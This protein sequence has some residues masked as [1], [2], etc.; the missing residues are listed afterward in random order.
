MKRYLIL[1][2]FTWL[3]SYFSFGQ[4]ILSNSSNT[5]S[6]QILNASNSNEDDL[7]KRYFYSRKSAEV[8][9][10]KV[11]LDFV[12]SGD[13]Q[14]SLSNG[15]DINA[16][17]GLGV[18]FELYNGNGD[19]ETK[20]TIQSLELEGIITVASTSD[21]II[22]EFEDEELINRR[23]FGT[24]VLNPISSKQSLYVNS[25]VFFNHPDDDD[26]FWKFIRR[27]I[28]HG[29]NMR[30]ITSNSVWKYNNQTSHL[31]ALYFRGGIFREFVP[32]N[33]RI[34][35]EGLNQGKVKYSIFL[36]LNYSYRNIIGDI[37]AD[38]YDDLREDIFG[39]KQTSFNGFEFNFGFR[40]NNLRAEFQMPILKGTDGSIEGLTDT[41]FL[42]SIK[43]I[44][45]FS[46]KLNNTEQSDGDE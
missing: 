28:L 2:M 6:G 18:V 22:A 34:E 30:V 29:V 33:H 46:L 1:C 11:Y 27:H 42:F 14:Q 7:S 41:Q 31:G 4:Q 38:K 24:Y 26:G 20:K 43:F 16:N 13:I 25:N 35:T 39:S 37:T 21:S 8:T 23:A 32:D 9:D 44:G 36:G 17:T 5:L 19:E 10:G 15:D 45:G 3:M 12:G 40:L